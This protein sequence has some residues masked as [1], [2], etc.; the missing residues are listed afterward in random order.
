M[1]TARAE[2]DLMPARPGSL[3]KKTLHAEIGRV[4]GDSGDVNKGGV[5]GAA[6]EIKGGGGDHAFTYP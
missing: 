2:P 5:E 1:K 6:R 3:H 4:G